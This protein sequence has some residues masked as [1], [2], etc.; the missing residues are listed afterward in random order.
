M[1]G[2]GGPRL[3]GA[4]GL[5]QGDPGILGGFRDGTALRA[6]SGQ[7]LARALLVL[8]LCGLPGFVR[9]APTL[10]WVSRRVLG[11][12]LWGGLLRASFYGQFV[13]GATPAEVGVTARRLQALGLR[14]ML[15]LPFE[16]DVG[17]P[18]SDGEHWYEGNGTAARGCV[19]LSTQGGPRP[20]MQLKVTALMSAH[21][22]KTVSGRL[23]EPGGAS[24][25][26]LDRVMAVMAGEDPQFP[27]LSPEQNRHLGAAL[28]RLDGVAQLASQRGVRVLVDAEQTYINP[29]LGLVTLALMARWNRDR[30][31]VWNTYQA[32]LQDCRARLQQDAGVA[33]RGGF[34]FGVKLVRGAYLQQERGLAR[35]RGCP[36]PAH[37]TWEATNAS[38][39]ACLDLALER[40]AQDGQRFELIVATHNEASVRHAVRRMAEL[41]IPEADGG[42]CFGQLLGMCDHVSLALGQAGYAVYKSVPYGPVEGVLPYLV[43]RAQEN[44]SVLAGV[45]AERALL[46]R[47]LCRRLLR[48]A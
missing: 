15:A 36:D 14:P 24:E 2:L 23:A 1:L 13:A 42:V 32:Y 40:A 37:P 11:R 33:E 18:R 3:R 10:L 39:D 46:T 27:W 48:R 35:A 9:S 31:W 22:C 7:E 44:R 30:A 4:A 47:E 17:G 20:M 34:C 43:R 5:P 28:S 6:K 45:R 19:E 41:G 26:S 8:G 29:A 21:L 12:R 16:E 25:L 38:Y